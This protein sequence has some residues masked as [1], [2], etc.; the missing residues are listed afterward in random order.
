MI[1]HARCRPGACTGPFAGRSAIWA[2][3]SRDLPGGAGRAG[4]RAGGPARSWWS[5]AVRGRGP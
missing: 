3:A 1:G 4:P 2:G 5:P